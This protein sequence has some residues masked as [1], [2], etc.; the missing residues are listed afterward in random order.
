MK[1]I[2]IDDTGCKREIKKAIK[3]FG[4]IDNY[5]VKVD[6][7]VGRWSSRLYSHYGK[8]FLKISGTPAHKMSKAI[9]DKVS[10]LEMSKLG[11]LIENHPDAY[12]KISVVPWSEYSTSDFDVYFSVYEEEIITP[13]TPEKKIE[14]PIDIVEEIIAIS[15]KQQSS[16][17]TKKKEAEKQRVLKEA[18]SLGL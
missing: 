11:E 15:E 7:I 14:L 13:E 2:Q 18:K 12:L 5:E 4:I 6:D 8:Y 1:Q 17:N 10:S 16:K 3:K 9:V